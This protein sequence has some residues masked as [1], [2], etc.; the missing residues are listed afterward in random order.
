MIDIDGLHLSLEDIISVARQRTEVQ[1][2]LGAIERITQAHKSVAATARS[3][4]VY[5]F[6]TGVGANRSVHLSSGSNHGLNLLRSHAADAGQL[7]DAPTVRAMLVIRLSQLA[8]AGSGINPQIPLALATMLNANA[9]PELREFGGIGTSD[10]PAL[11]GTAL[12]LLGERPTLDG[13]IYSQGLKDWA[14]EDALPF[15]SSNALTIARSVL[16]YYDL[17]VINEQSVLT[18]ALSFVAL[19]GNP[20]PFSPAVAACL[21]SG[22]IAEGYRRIFDLVRN[23]GT[24]VRLQDPFAL[25]TMAQLTGNVAEELAAT[26][27]RLTRLVVSRHE[28]P[29]VIGTVAEGNNDIAHHGLFLMLGLA[30]RLDTVRQIL[31]TNAATCLRRISFLCDPEYTGLH[32]FLA[33]D[34]FGQSGVMVI[35]YVAAAA[36]S[37]LRSHAQPVSQQSVVLS[38]GVEDDASFASEA[39]ALL[40]GSVD[41]L[42]VMTACEMLC[43]VRALRQL[44]VDGEHFLSL[45]TREFFSR[46]L[47]LP[48]AM[49]DR[50]LRL[51]LE[52]AQRILGA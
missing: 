15:I 22:A 14:T 1:L 29:L 9:L 20:E 2:T 36:L 41:A 5:G 3:R 8:A 16:A 38:L 27:E 47:D 46:A 30:K 44:G 12:T 11:A 48:E 37:R 34:G 7:L 52:V 23:A 19:S 42:R 25:R 4:P 18:S 6:S 28:N 24:P 39:A 45:E 49:E 43:S 51:D 32:R 13:S 31:A 17:K 33:Q 10:L 40:V 26:E 35:E 50:D 21:D